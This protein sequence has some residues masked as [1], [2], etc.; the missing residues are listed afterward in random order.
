M[1]RLRGCW[2]GSNSE[3]LAGWVGVGIIKCRFL[4]SQPHDVIADWLAAADAMVLMSKSEGLANAWIEALASGTPPVISDV[5]SAREVLNGPE[6]GCFAD[7]NAS[8]IAHAIQWVL[9]RDLDR[10]AVAATVDRFSWDA[11]TAALYAHLAGLV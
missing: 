9:A 10:Q 2:H 11:N 1:Y 6:V 3:W 5:G 8:S 7:F 4:G